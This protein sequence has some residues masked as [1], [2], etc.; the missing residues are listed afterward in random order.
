MPSL[1]C[2]S[3]HQQ[4]FAGACRTPRYKI[5]AIVP[6]DGSTS[7]SCCVSCCVSSIS[8]R[9]RLRNTR[10]NSQKIHQS[11]RIILKLLGQT[12][13]RREMAHRFG[14]IHN[15]VNSKEDRKE[16]TRC[17]ITVVC[18]LSNTSCHK[19]LDGCLVTKHDENNERCYPSRAT[20]EAAFSMVPFCNAPP[21]SH[22]DDGE[23]S[24]PV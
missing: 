13:D 17:M 11:I 22:N 21:T 1:I 4:G 7:I 9:Q 18:L 14:R 23:Y 2:H 24:C 6:F 8:H 15:K 19:G 3:L 12:R 10:W 5:L 16:P 20:A